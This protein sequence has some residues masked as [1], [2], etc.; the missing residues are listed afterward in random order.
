M[1]CRELYRSKES[2]TTA[3][4]VIC[5]R[6]RRGLPGL[7]TPSGRWRPSVNARFRH[8]SVLAPI[9]LRAVPL[10]L[11][12][13]AEPR[14]L[15]RCWRV[16]A[17]PRNGMCALSLGNMGSSQAKDARSPGRDPRRCERW[18]AFSGS[19]RWLCRPSRLS[20]EGSA[21]NPPNPQN[22]K[23]RPPSTPSVDLSF[24]GARRRWQYELAGR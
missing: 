3:S 6:H 11:G 24:P 1:L 9:R 10:H 15:S 12:A 4:G 7:C 14:R 17:S 19:T 20:S 23:A 2:D 16:W 18:G 21:T 13:H 22:L 8:C 5:T